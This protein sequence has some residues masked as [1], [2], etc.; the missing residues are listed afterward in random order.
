M[1]FKGELFLLTLGMSKV[2]IRV[3]KLKT[4]GNIA[5]SGHH[6]FRETP[7]PNADGDRTEL[8]IA[9]GAENTSHLLDAVR[10]RLPD[11]R[12]KDAVLCLE[13]LITASPEYFGEDWREKKNHGELYFSDSI[14]WLKKKHGEENVVCSNVQLDESTPHL[15]VYV[16]PRSADGRLS[17]KEFIGGRAKLQKLQTDFAKDVGEQHGL[18]RGIEGSKARHTSIKEYYSGV[19]E[20]FEPLPEVKTPVPKLRPEPEK[21]GLFAG[22]DT[23]EEYQ[24]DHA[25]WEREEAIAQRQKQKHMAEVKAQRD[26]A[27]ET[28]RRHQA[29][30]KEAQA[31]KHQVDQLKQFNGIYAQTIAQLKDKV[32]ELLTIIGLFTPEEMQV[33]QFRKQQQQAE[34]VRLETEKA[35]LER[36]DELARSKAEKLASV[37]AEAT[38]RIEA[39][40]SLLKRAGADYI[41]GLEAEK[42]L[43]EAGGNAVKI[44]WRAVEARA[45]IEAMG[46][47]GQ[48]AENVTTALLTHSP[49]RAD[50]GSH[51]Q[52][53]DAIK[54]AT[55]KF[56]ADFEKHRASQEYQPGG[57]RFN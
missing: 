57:N 24:L 15:V 14:N 56:E 21:P 27:V 41:F 53:Q 9:G 29:Q 48:S 33:A 31:L 26:V 39:I 37:E 50:P 45:V 34:K 23:K 20:A 44:D 4:I 47:Q 25:S 11:K 5:A 42:A 28:A 1:P 3:A 30:A 52:L 36:L 43:Q 8:N 54:I 40:P 55:P 17:A 19:N 51:A 35:R 22:K 13:Y 32:S 6:T 10:G 16:V 2:I 18:Q 46:R 7:T 12:R 49:L 38:R